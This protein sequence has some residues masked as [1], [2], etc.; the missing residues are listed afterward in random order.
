M[1]LSNSAIGQHK[2][3]AMGKKVGFANGGAVPAAMP[4]LPMR[5]RVAVPMNPLTKAKMANG[6]P[7]FKKGGKC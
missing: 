2:Q 4:S 5:P 1:A 3:M 7:G 6:V